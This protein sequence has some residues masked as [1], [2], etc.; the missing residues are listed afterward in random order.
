M[1]MRQN[2]AKQVRREERLTQYRGTSAFAGD[3]PCGYVTSV[4]RG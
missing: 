3:S 1:A 2:Q 4:D